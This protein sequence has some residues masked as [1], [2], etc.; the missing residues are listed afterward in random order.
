MTV[1]QGWIIPATPWHG[2]HGLLA[3]GDW[4]Y[5]QERYPISVIEMPCRDVYC[6]F[7]EKRVM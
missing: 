4:L 1:L 5:F 7:V 3:G 2:G 6:R